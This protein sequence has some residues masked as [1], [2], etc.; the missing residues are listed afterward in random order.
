LIKV[1]DILSFFKR[2]FQVDTI[3]LYLQTKK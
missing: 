3:Y 2:M 1:S